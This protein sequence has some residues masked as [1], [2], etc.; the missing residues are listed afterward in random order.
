M[1]VGRWG[2]QQE[3]LPRASASLQE[4]CPRHLCTFFSQVADGPEK[5]HVRVRK[6][7]QLKCPVQ[8]P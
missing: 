3:A 4:F 1:R 5:Q 2:R 7:S 6:Q 8:V